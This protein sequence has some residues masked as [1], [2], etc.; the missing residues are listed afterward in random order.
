MTNKFFKA[1]LRLATRRNILLLTM[2]CLIFVLILLVAVGRLSKTTSYSVPVETRRK[3]Q[4]EVTDRASKYCIAY[5]SVYEHKLC[6][7]S[8]LT[9]KEDVPENFFERKLPGE[10]ILM[11]LPKDSRF[12]PGYISGGKSIDTTIELSHN[13]TLTAFDLF[14]VG[15]Y[16]SDVCT[17]LKACVPGIMTPSIQYEMRESIINQ[18]NQTRIKHLVGQEP[19]GERHIFAVEGVAGQHP[20]SVWAQIHPDNP[21][22]S[23]VALTKSMLLSASFSEE[24]DFEDGFVEFS[25]ME[26]GYEPELPRN[27]QSFSTESMFFTFPLPTESD[28]YKQAEI[29]PRM[30]NIS[31]KKKGG[32]TE[33][34]SVELVAADAIKVPTKDI[35]H[36]QNAE[37][38]FVISLDVYMLQKSPF[39]FIRYVCGSG[40]IRKEIYVSQDITITVCGFDKQIVSSLERKTVAVFQAKHL[41]A[42]FTEA[43]RQLTEKDG[44]KAPNTSFENF[45]LAPSWLPEA[46]SESGSSL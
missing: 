18:E 29:V 32:D 39:D 10:P 44:W 23:V 20:Y 4:Q 36:A 37:E 1:A 21:S 26:W 24:W 16:N 3:L 45:E 33:S 11:P 8:N 46:S 2:L 27:W 42:F 6:G 7:A 19:S 40:S 25:E 43:L 34:Y 35:F 22:A 17:Q 13:G 41:T 38:F 28:H 12:R 5:P 15:G 14:F 9:K 30:I 31:E